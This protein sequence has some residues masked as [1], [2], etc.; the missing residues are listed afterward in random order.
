MP[1]CWILASLLGL[2][3]F[4]SIRS[5]LLGI[6]NLVYVKDSVRRAWQLKLFDKIYALAGALLW[7]AFVA[8]SEVYLRKRADHRDLLWRIAIVVGPELLLVTIIQIAMLALQAF[9]AA[10]GD[11]WLAIG[12]EGLL[13]TGCLVAAHLLK[14]HKSSP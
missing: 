12:I 2:W 13:G 3:L 9:P 14:S 1:C 11:R 8:I 4:I 5:S 6:A 7:L 10:A